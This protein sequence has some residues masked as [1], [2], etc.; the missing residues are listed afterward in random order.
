MALIKVLL[1]PYN[2]L[3]LSRLITERSETEY[4]CIKQVVAS[5]KT[6]RIRGEGGREGGGLPFYTLII[7]LTGSIL[8]GQ[9]V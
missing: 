1:A 3:L 7:L 6:G 5:P 4:E 2:Q 9:T 8:P